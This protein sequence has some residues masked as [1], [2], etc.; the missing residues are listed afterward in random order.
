MADC[1]TE[2]RTIWDAFGTWREPGLIHEVGL[3]LC[4]RHGVAGC[5]L[6][7]ERGEFVLEWRIRN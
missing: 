5:P 2:A 6:C 7:Y 1:N 3:L 4:D